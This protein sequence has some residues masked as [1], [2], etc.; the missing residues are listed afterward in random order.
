MQRIAAYPNRIAAALLVGLVIAICVNALLLQRGRHPAPLFYR[1]PPLASTQT[2]LARQMGA[3]PQ[4]AFVATNAS[5]RDPIAQLLQTAPA[6][7]TPSA[8]S[9]DAISQL[10]ASDKTQRAPQPDREV[11]AAQRALVKLGFVLKPDGFLGNTTRQAIVQFERDHKLPP[12][13]EVDARLLR[14]LNANSGGVAE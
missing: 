3:A 5:A 9:Q 4:P 11:L 10:L 6:G 2:Q 7:A 1:N 8:A 13:G 14:E 12:R